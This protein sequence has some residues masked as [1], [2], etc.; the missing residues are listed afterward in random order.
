MVTKE[1]HCL[2]DILM[3]SYDGSLNVDIAAVVGNYDTLQSLTEKFDIPYHYI[4]HIGLDREEHEKKMLEVI[5]QYNADYLV[6]AKFM[7]VLTPSFV[8]NHAT[9]S[10]TFITA[11]SLRL[12]ALGLTNKPMIEV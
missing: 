4:S 1:A 2:G 7:R 12:L 10:L 6:L 5:D 9:R 3:K 8:E 11:F